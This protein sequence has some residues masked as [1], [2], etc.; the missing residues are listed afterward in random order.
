MNLNDKNKKYRKD[1]G[2]KIKPSARINAQKERI[3]KHREKTN[4][5]DKMRINK[6]CYGGNMGIIL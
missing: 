6:N 5:F 2:W 3:I 4:P 1:F